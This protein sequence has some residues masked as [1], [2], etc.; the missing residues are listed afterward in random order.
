MPSPDHPQS[1]LVD[2]LVVGGGI[3]GL[4]IAEEAATR[5]L[6][7]CVVE[8]DDWGG[9]TTAASSRLIH[10]GLRYLQYGELPLVYESLRERRDLSRRYPFHVRPIRLMLPL[11]PRQPNRPWKVRV[12]LTTY[13]LLARDPIFPAS[14]FLSPGSAL[15]REPGLAAEE[16]MGAWLYSDAQI[17]FPERLCIQMMLAA[18]ARGA[19]AWNHT[20]IREF[21]IE[22]NRHRRTVVGALVR[23]G[24]TGVVTEVR[25]RATVNAA[26]P[27]VDVVNRLLPA[28]PLLQCTWGTHL[29][30]PLRPG[31][32]RGPIYVPARSDGRPLFF[33]PWDGRLLVG[34]TDRVLRGDP[35][36][37]RAD[38]DEIPYLL[39]ELHHHFP[40]AG[41]CEGDLQH[42]TFGLRPLPASRGRAGFPGSVTRRHFV[43]DHA[44]RDGISGLASLVGGKLTTH[45]ALARSAVDWVDRHLGRAPHRVAQDQPR[46]PEYPEY[47]DHA[48]HERIVAGRLRSAGLDPESA[49]RLLALYG[50]RVDHVIAVATKI[51]EPDPL[52]A[53][54]VKIALEEEGA[55]TVEDILNRRLV[56]L[57]APKAAES[58]VAAVLAAWRA[59]GGAGSAVG[60]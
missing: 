5:G 35:D 27:W 34:T 44:R 33:L 6:S 15:A 45:R 38:P 47:P 23:G 30:L 26:G 9:G 57:P 19:L 50:S 21:L 13:D 51:R 52:L 4:A 25:A 18:T 7:V 48:D 28:A 42:T 31:C 60:Q 10:G 3:N 54:Q 1:P 36:E 2:L 43:I 17:A 58:Y 56:L 46:P 22:A 55:A 14:K 41:Y 37:A 24:E 16:L 32:P 40:S 59:G 12:G 49:P 39:A 53:A 20:H 8:R 29:I 11:Y